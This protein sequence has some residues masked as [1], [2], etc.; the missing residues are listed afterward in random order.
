M[1]QSGSD[2]VP[3]DLPRG[4]HRLGREVVLAS[5]RERML[6][7]MAQTVAA[8]GYPQT[9]V[10]DVVAGAGVSRKTFYEHF[11][12]REDCFLAAYDAGVERLLTAIVT[13]APP[14]RTP[15]ALMRAR[16]RAYL[17]AL[18]AEPAFA[19]AFMLDVFAAGERALERRAEVHRR[20]EQLI[21]D[22]YEQTRAEVPAL[23][24]LAP[25]TCAAAVGAVNELVTDYIRAGRTT[26]LL[27]LEDALVRVQ[28][29][30]LLG[31]S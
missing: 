9:T 17:A 18:A 13:A 2:V 8:K 16:V 14:Q 10:G 31:P 1:A 19:R 26:D 29:A 24:P 15:E 4:P 6:D 23:P 27:Q 12:D 20:F 7:A 3:R 21:G 30:L 28:T 11:K 22:L 5:Q 25:E